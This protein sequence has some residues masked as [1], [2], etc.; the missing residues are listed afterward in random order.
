MKSISLWNYFQVCWSLMGA[1]ET[2]LGRADVKAVYSKHRAVG[3][4]PGYS[5]LDLRVVCAVEGLKEWQEVGD[6]MKETYLRLL[7]LNSSPLTRA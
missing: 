4:T 2:L 7:Y 3:L 5:D 6:A 1:S